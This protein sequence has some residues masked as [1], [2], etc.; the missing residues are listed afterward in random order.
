VRRCP[1][2]DYAA[3]V[4]DAMPVEPRV[5]RWSEEIRVGTELPEE[6]RGKERL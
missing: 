1:G 2:F 6:G 3:V 4:I 5:I